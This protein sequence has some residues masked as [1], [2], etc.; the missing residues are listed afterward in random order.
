M[1]DATVAAAEA[2]AAAA[3]RRPRA[4]ILVTGSEL[5]LGQTQDRNSGW[6]AGR[7]DEHGVRLER[8][9]TVDDDG[10][11]IE[12]GLRELLDRGV[13]LILTSG[14]LG[15]THD[16]RTVA[17]VAAVVGRRLVVDEPTLHR[18]DE[19]TAAFAAGR[20]LDPAAWSHG[21][22]K[23]ASV[24]EGAA[25]LPPVGTAP[26]VVVSVGEQ[27]V[28]VLPGPPSELQTMWATLPAHPDLAHLLGGPAGPRRTLRLYGTPESQ[29]ADVFAA[30]GGDGHGTE[31]TICASRSE[32][33][34]VI[35]DAGGGEGAVG[36]LADGLEARLGAAVYATDP[37]PLEKLLVDRLRSARLT[38][39]TAES[40]TA[41]L[42]ASRLGAVAGVSDVLLGGVVSYADAVKADLLDVPT[43]L[44]ER[45]GAVSAAVAAAMAEGA[46][47]TV[48]ADL[49]V[50]VTGIAGPGGATPGKPVGLV[51]LHA[52]G[53]D[54]GRALERRF[55]GDRQTV[56]EWSAT[57]AL[58][59]V[60]A[61]VE[62]G[63]DRT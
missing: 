29:V 52:A 12:E 55:R 34:V 26:G 1:A 56:R 40:C 17:A 30:L 31:T 48:G 18:I 37:R 7:L 20:G 47:R 11:G 16:D 41:G 62:D 2:P 60:R 3:A 32:I 21:N 50:S 33:S 8:V 36:H 6:L 45:H 61:L 15:P 14:G 58:H 24:P 27:R 9:L 63:P 43:A 53:P 57:A 51:F 28:V 59:L 10:A 49:A 39:A 19:I 54:G 23:Q 38:L 25:V 44:L 42:V 46:R 22:R 35:R 5:L 4:G 13:D